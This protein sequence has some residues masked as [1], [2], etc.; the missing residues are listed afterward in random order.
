MRFVRLLKET[1]E[2][3]WN[4]Y[5]ENID[6]GNIWQAHKYLID[7]PSDHY[8]S[9]ILNL[10]CAPTNKLPNS[11][12]NNTK[13]QLWYETFFKLAPNAPLTHINEEYPGPAACFT[14][15]MNDQIGRAIYK[16]TLPL[17]GTW[18]EQNMQCHLH[19]LHQQTHPTH[20][21]NIQSH[22]WPE[23][24][25][26]GVEPIN[27]RENLDTQTTPYQNPINPLPYWTSWQRFYPHVLRKTWLTW[28]NGTTSFLTPILGGDPVGPWWTQYSY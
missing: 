18:T 10:R 16:E 2:N 26:K 4:E 12:L 28:Q 14:N 5:L 20:G 7:E 27:N 19:E 8:Q 22:L 17:Q 15:I 13:S 9:H 3:H 21:T 24:L 25:P 6:E 11:Q 23:I 1:K